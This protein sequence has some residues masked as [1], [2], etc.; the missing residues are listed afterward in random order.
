MI[1]VGGLEVL[2]KPTGM[3]HLVPPIKGAYVVNIGDLMRKSRFVLKP[4]LFL[5]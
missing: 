2:H 3:W 5:L 1:S 4:R